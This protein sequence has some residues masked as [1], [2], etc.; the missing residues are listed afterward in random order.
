[1]TISFPGGHCIYFDNPATSFPKPP[2]V[3]DAVLHYMTGVGGNPGRSGHL[4]SMAAAEIVQSTREAIAGL[5]HVDNPRQVIFCSNATDALY[6]AI[7]GVIRE[8]D[9][10]I[11]TSMEHNSTLRPLVELE[12]RERMTLSVARCTRE[13]VVDVPALLKTITPETRVMVV[14]HASN[15]N[16]TVQPLREIGALCRE[17][18]I[19][20][21]ADCAQSAG[22]IDIDMK[23]DGVDLLAFSGHKG[24]Y[25][26]TGTGGLVIA[27][28]FDETFLK[29]L[30]YGGTGSYSDK[31]LQPP[32]LPDRFESG[33]LN[34]AGIS[35]LAAGVA[36]ITAVPGGLEGIR[37]H[38]AKLVGYFLQ[39]ALQEVEGLVTYAPEPLIETG[40]LSFNIRRKAPSAVAKLLGDEYG[41]MCR[42]GMH[43]APLAH[44]TMAT[45]PHGT[46]RFGFG[47]FNTEEEIDR[48]VDALR[49][50]AGRTI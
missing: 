22:V 25:G 6:L 34:V 20:L 43:C 12:Q 3:I 38:K 16:G 40:V 41:I 18:G 7:Q 45:F 42:S 17:R 46:V 19:I 44:Q 28:D 8:G 1:M 36:H 27:D 21:V 13:G 35:G 23:A 26:P 39:R 31:P 10:V 47:L 4:L 37:R 24:L 5:F 14:N 48:A 2:T 32:F 30:K 49:D 29:P 11:T 33:T 9:H 15:V 50:I